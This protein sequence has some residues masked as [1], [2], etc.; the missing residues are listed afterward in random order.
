M[1]CIEEAPRFEPDTSEVEAII[2][3]YLSDLLDPMRLTTQFITTS[4]ARNVEVPV[5][6]LEGHTV[7]GATAMMLNEIREILQR[8]Q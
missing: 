1:G 7:W 8:S 5:F 3:V 6:E 2:E 4:Y